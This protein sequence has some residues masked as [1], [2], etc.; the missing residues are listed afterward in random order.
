MRILDEK[1]EHQSPM[2]LQT[3]SF[4]NNQYEVGLPW[5]EGHP[6]VPNHFNVCVNRLRLLHR[7]LLGTPELL[8]EY[9][10]I[11]QEQLNK[12]IVESVPS[13]SLQDGVHYL[14]HH[15]GQAN[16]QASHCLQWLYEIK[17]R[18]CI[19]EQLS[20]DRSELDTQAFQCFD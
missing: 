16:N 17:Y 5:K 2:F 7:R 11:I 4:N 8:K 15:G 14:L 18:C 3:I 10:R 1:H 19:P 12:G 9:D 6:D 13:D 20:R